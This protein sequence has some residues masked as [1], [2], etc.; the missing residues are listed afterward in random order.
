[1]IIPV[2][3][4]LK[5]ESQPNKHYALVFSDVMGVEDFIAYRNALTTAVKACLTSDSAGYIDN[6]LF[7]LVQ[8]SE[9]ISSSIDEASKIEDSR[10]YAEECLKE[11]RDEFKKI[12]LDLA[13]KAETSETDREKFL[14]LRERIGRYVLPIPIPEIDEDVLQP[15]LEKIKKGSN[16]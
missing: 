2:N 10:K 12:F 5:G 3:V 13:K 14:E 7:W 1:M 6:E 15:L 16:S 8:L 11:T 4:Q 9:F